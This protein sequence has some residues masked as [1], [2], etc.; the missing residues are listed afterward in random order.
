MSSS[1]KTMRKYLLCLL[2]KILFLISETAIAEINWGNIALFSAGFMSAVPVHELGHVAAIKI[3]G[4]D[5]TDIGFAYTRGEFYG[6]STSRNRKSRV[7][8]LS[9]YV[10]AS[11]TTEVILANKNW[12]N[13]AYALGMMSL[14]IYMNIA[15]VIKYY[16]F[17]QKNDLYVYRQTGANPLIPSIIMVMH[18]LWS[19]NRIKHNTD[20]LFNIDTNIVSI[21]YQIKNLILLGLYN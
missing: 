16:L 17:E 7:T 8:A 12:H 18:A 10:A 2:V 9:G 19:M 11:L 1:I 5:V 6:D 4:G 21:G 14:G 3:Q 13:N 20:I 15:N